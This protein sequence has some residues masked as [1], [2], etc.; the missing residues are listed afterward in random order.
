MKQPAI[1]NNV[2]IIRMFSD[3]LFFAVFL[4]FGEDTSFIAYIADNRTIKFLLVYSS[5]SR[6]LN[7]KS[8]RLPLL[9]HLCAYALF[10]GYYLGF[11]NICYPLL[12][13][14]VIDFYYLRY[15]NN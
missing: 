2:A 14:F 11:L 4:L 9:A 3:I 8:F 12:D 7:M 15:I 10:S 6:P 13:I 1:I 5:I